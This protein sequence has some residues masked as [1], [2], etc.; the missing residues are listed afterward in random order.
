MH[1]FC[2]QPRKMSRWLARNAPE[3]EPKSWTPPLFWF[4][5]GPAGLHAPEFKQT[6]APDE[7]HPTHL[8]RSILLTL[9]ADKTFPQTG[10][11]NPLTLGKTKAAAR[12]GD[13]WC[14]AGLLPHALCPGC[15]RSSSA[16][17]LVTRARG[18]VLEAPPWSRAGECAAQL[19]LTAF[20]TQRSFNTQEMGNSVVTAGPGQTRRLQNKAHVRTARPTA[21]GTATARPTAPAGSPWLA[22]QWSLKP[23]RVTTTRPRFILL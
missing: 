7:K 9:R 18:R 4:C 23:Q 5:C 10:K 11:R 16:E 20:N 14:V 13:S 21:P 17:A 12:A 8:C 3:A 2:P 19:L 22:L 15:P 6:S 1:L